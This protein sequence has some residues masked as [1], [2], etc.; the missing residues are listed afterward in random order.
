MEYDSVLY[1]SACQRLKPC[2]RQS[3]YKWTQ[4]IRNYK[5]QQKKKTRK[6][7]LNETRSETEHFFILTKS[8]VYKYYL[9]RWN[10]Q[11]KNYVNLVNCLY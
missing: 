11:L 5:L 8:N 10:A 4:L 6:E 7:K 2:N 1:L 3:T 9:H